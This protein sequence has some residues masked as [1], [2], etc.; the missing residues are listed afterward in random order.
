MNRSWALL[1]VAFTACGGRVGA[2]ELP[3]VGAHASAAPQ[4]TLLL[5]PEPSPQRLLGHAVTHT[6]NGTATIEQDVAPG[7]DVQIHRAPNVVKFNRVTELREATLLGGGYATI[8]SLEAKWGKELKTAVSATNAEV[9]RA[10]LSG[11]CGDEVVSE[12]FVGTGERTILRSAEV[13]GTLQ[14]GGLGATA[15]ADTDRSVRALDS[16]KWTDPQVYAFN[17]RH[18][19]GA[20]LFDVDVRVPPRIVEGDKVSIDI[21]TSEDAFLV[22]YYVGADGK[23]DVIL[24]ANEDPRPA[25]KKATPFSIPSAAQAAAGVSFRAQLADKT[26]PQKD[27][28]LVYAFRSEGDFKL[29]RN[30][31]EQAGGEAQKVEMLLE[32]R[33]SG[34]PTQRWGKRIVTYEILPR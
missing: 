1:L 9:V 17:T 10:E 15:K 2:P 25:T 12:V 20:S 29:V 19:A 23:A 28:L 22:V 30:S 3:I 11:P 4:G 14:T 32:A 18:M 13:G 31:I 7:C 21:T 27:R 24:P 26:K 34:I 16:I 5:Y 8:A 6:A 33:L